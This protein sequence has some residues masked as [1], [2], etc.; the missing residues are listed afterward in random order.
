MDKRTLIV[1][2]AG[3]FLS[4]HV[5]AEPFEMD[6]VETENVQVL[7]FAATQAYI[8]PHLVRSF[9]NS[10]AFQKE[11]FEWEPEGRVVL[12]LTD[13]SDYGNA[14]AGVSPQ[15]GV[16]MDVAPMSHAFE[17]VVG[18][19]RVFANMNHELVHL[20]NLDA[21]NEQDRK[22]RRFFG[23]KPRQTSAHPETILY[24]YLA[25][26]RVNVPRWYSEG[27]ATFME[28]WMSGGVGRAQGAYDEMVFRAMVRD[29]AHFYSPLGIVSEGSSID[30]QVGVNAYLY[31][32]RFMSYLALAHSPE[33][34]IE[35]LKRGENSE[36]Y[37]AHQFE[38]VFGMT[39]EE[40]WQDWVDWEHEFQAANLESVRAFPP[41]PVTP[42]VPTALGSISKSYYDPEGNR[43]LGGFRYPGVVA[44]MGA[45]DLGD[46][47]VERF[48][49]IKG[50]MLYRVTST[51][52]D[53]DAQTLFYTTDAGA[54]RDLRA[55]DLAT[56]E[57]RMLLEDARIG[58][59]AF[60][61]AD[62]SL[63]GLRHLNGLVTLVRIPPPYDSW[64]QVHTWPYLQVAFELDVSPDGSL[65]SAS[66]AEIDGEQYLR[67]FRTADLLA[68]R[69]EPVH[70][71]VFGLAI[72]EGFVFSPDGRFL[73]GSSYYTGV[74]NIFRYDLESEALEAVSNAETGFFR[75]IP[76][77][78]GRLIVFE[79]TGQGFRPGLIDPQPLED[80]GAVRFL[81]NEIASQHPVVRD[82]NVVQT[83]REQD[84]DSLVIGEDSYRPYRE[85]E[86]GSRYPVLLG[87]RDEFALGYH[88]Q[89]HDPA[90]MHRFGLT[91]SYS[92]DT[93]SDESLHVNAEYHGINWYARYWHNYAD[94]YDL[95]GPTE[96]ARKGDAFIFGY[97]KALI[98]DVPRR[99]DFYADAAWYTGL[100][101]LPDNQNRPTFFIDEILTVRSGLEYRD[102]RQSLGGVDREKGWAWNLEARVDHSTFDTIPKLSGGLDYGLALPWK[103]SSVWLY[104]DLGWADGDRLDPLAN[105][106]FGGFGNNYVDDGVVKRYRE[107]Y[108]LPGFEIGEIGGREFGKV[109]AEWNLPPI[110]FRTRPRIY[111]HS[112]LT[113]DALRRLGGGL[114]GRRPQR[115]GVDGVAEN[116]VTASTGAARYGPTPEQGV[117]T[118][119]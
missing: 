65:L 95:F 14:G 94:F 79:Y 63:W 33:Q 19:E 7:H 100:D 74:S 54:F 9:E 70:E 53:P 28:T 6:R 77:E 29:D 12:L 86:L 83:L 8:V 34:V 114:R 20:A 40:A 1:T 31:G 46:G 112:S 88:F 113:H 81:G 32:T 118:S 36:R 87:Y 93:P 105:Y 101:T 119:D 22:W 102:L 92:W 44:H 62:G 71:V 45:L 26:P 42:L 89:W 30:F 110:R 66:V 76:L 99:L 96:R 43:M 106:Y 57:D 69:A 39:L 115:P 68:G 109:T 75:P 61:R 59:L 56:G 48:S 27:A 91:A 35:W 2:L 3:L 82:W 25:T 11:I 60:N 17:T 24:N 55:I 18:S 78:D 10:L 21:W 38:Q 84:Y 117:T 52:Y 51:A 37:Y 50:P 80:V 90:Q 107:F 49:D 67:V 47:I 13:F 98:Y 111:P 72:P 15:N 58:D 5:R 85:L 103:H 104:S 23:G 108:S 73:F 16:V 64:N 4:L 41:T 116:L 97:E